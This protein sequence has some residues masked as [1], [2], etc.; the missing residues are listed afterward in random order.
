M[1]LYWKFKYIKEISD[2]F[3]FS[4]I[5]SSKFWN[6]NPFTATWHILNFWQLWCIFS[7]AATLEDILA[8]NNKIYSFIPFFL[9]DASIRLTVNCSILQWKDERKKMSCY[10]NMVILSF[11]SSPQSPCAFHWCSSWRHWVQ[12]PAEPWSRPAM[13]RAALRL[14][15]SPWCQHSPSQCDSQHSSVFAHGPGG[16]TSFRLFYCCVYFFVWCAVVKEII[17][18]FDS[19][20][21]SDSQPRKRFQRLSTN[22]TK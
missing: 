18:L 7:S 13:S 22:L 11:L 20:R 6:Y 15:A 5:F 2:I 9:V 16:G 1:A 19:F 12:P 3:L 8:T 14:A 10:E 21:N 17:S 4:M